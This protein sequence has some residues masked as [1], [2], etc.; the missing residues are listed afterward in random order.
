[1]ARKSRN[2]KKQKLFPKVVTNQ[3]ALIKQRRK[4]RPNLLSKWEASKAALGASRKNRWVELVVLEDL[5][6][7]QYE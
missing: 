4:K 3:L 1:M 2:K 6:R 7:K 5:K